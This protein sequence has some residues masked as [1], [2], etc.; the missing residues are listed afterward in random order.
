M[1]GQLNIKLNNVKGI[2][3]TL[4]VFAHLLEINKHP[5]INLFVFIYSFHMPLF[6][7]LSGYFSKSANLKKIFKMGVTLLIFQVFYVLLTKYSG[8]N[9]LTKLKAAT[10]PVFHLWYLLSMVVWYLI[11]IVLNK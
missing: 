6:V 10:I 3:I 1:K 9:D 8:F 5:Y 7:F 11:V 4:V 2:L